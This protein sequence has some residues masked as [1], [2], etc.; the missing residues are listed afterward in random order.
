MKTESELFENAIISFKKT[1][2]KSNE[3]LKILTET[4]K[5]DGYTCTN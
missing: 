1:E 5:R 3:S 2:Y 4:W